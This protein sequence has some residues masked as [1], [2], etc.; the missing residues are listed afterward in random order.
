MCR[1]STLQK[2]VISWAVGP[3]PEDCLVA[4]IQTAAKR[5]FKGDHK[6]LLQAYFIGAK[7]N[8]ATKSLD[9]VLTAA[10]SIHARLTPGDNNA[11]PQDVLPGIEDDDAIQD[12]SDAITAYDTKNKAQA[13]QQ[14]RAAATLESVQAHITQLATLRHDIQLAADQAFPWRKPGVKTIRKAFLLPP[15]RPLGE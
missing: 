8:L 10:R 7:L 4:P 3:E 14:S 6:P 2:S 12:L 11:P 5:T 15:D 9:E 13:E 1:G